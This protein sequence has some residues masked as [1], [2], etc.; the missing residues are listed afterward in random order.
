MEPAL[1]DVGA[2]ILPNAKPLQNGKSARLRP[3]GYLLGVHILV[4]WQTQPVFQGDTSGYVTSIVA[5]LSGM[6]LEFW[7][8][9]HL[10]WRPFCPTKHGR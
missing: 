2:L 3:Y 8:F 10:L 4:T 7:D 6:Y 5:R 9:G 1:T